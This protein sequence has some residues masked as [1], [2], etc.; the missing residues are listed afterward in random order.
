MVCLDV[1]VLSSTSLLLLLSMLLSTLVVVLVLL[2]LTETFLLFMA[3]FLKVEL[4]LLFSWLLVPFLLLTA[5]LVSPLMVLVLLFMSSKALSMM[6]LSGFGGTGGGSF[7]PSLPALLAVFVAAGRLER[8]F[9][10]VVGFFRLSDRLIWALVTAGLLGFDRIEDVR[11]TDGKVGS[12]SA[13]LRATLGAALA[14]LVFFSDS[15]DESRARRPPG[16][17]DRSRAV[18]GTVTD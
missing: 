18:L 5:L 14:V 2:L 12:L 6:A 9:L 17:A 16:D 1:V 4:L 15:A 13:A 3:I 8:S 10:A 7:F 11:L